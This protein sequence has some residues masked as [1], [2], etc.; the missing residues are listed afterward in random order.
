MY[1]NTAGGGT[2]EVWRLRNISS[3]WEC[4][5]DDNSMITTNPQ[6][7]PDSYPEEKVKMKKTHW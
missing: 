3:K 4:D 6:P 7:N 2:M 5:T 1:S